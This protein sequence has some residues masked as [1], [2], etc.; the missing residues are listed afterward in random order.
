[1]AFFMRILIQPLQA[2]AHQMW[3]YA[4]STDATRVSKDEVAE[5]EVKKT[6]HWLTTLTTTDEVPIAC[7]AERF[8]KDHPLPLVHYVDLSP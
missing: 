4:G 3:N 8:N 1:M 5:D 7:Q 6:V 2:R